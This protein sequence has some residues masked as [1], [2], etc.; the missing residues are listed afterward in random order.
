MNLRFDLSHIF[1][2]PICHFT[3]VITNFAIVFCLIIL[4]NFRSIFCIIFAHHFVQSLP[5]HFVD[6]SV[7]IMSI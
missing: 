6:K 4:Y 7:L 5:G 2:L 3:Y 1:I